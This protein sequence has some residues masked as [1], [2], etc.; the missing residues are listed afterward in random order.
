MPLEES[1]N[2]VGTERKRDA[3]VVLAP[4]GDIFVRV[5]PKQVAEKACDRGGVKSVVGHNI[6]ARSA[7]RRESEATDRYRGRLSGA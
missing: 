7:M 2:D 6:S 5:G 4:A 3:P 1:G